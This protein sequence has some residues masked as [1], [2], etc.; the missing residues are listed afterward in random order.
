MESRA[1]SF[2]DDEAIDYDIEIEFFDGLRFCREKRI[3]IGELTC[4]ADADEARFLKPLEMNLEAAGETAERGGE[5][6]DAGALGERH[7]LGCY[8]GHRVA[9]Y[10]RAGLRVVGLTGGG[11]KE[12]GVVVDLGGGG[13]G[14]AWVWRGGALLDR[15][16]GGEAFD[17]IDVGLFEAVEKLPR[18]GRKAFDIAALAF[19]VE[20]IEGERG[21]PRSA[22]ASDDGELIARDLDVD[23]LEVVLAGAGDA[24]RIGHGGAPYIKG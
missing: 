8:A 23:I 6:D 5:Q 7:D 1:E 17:E 24:D 15:D 12:P 3:D 18:I 11:E 21:F 19:G 2:A 9:V 14:R 16:G 13:D 4:G 10:W 22:D 20:G